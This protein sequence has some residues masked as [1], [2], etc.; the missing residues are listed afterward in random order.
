MAPTRLFR[1]LLFISLSVFGEQGFAQSPFRL[2]G[3]VTD[4]NTG[5]GVPFASVAIQSS[6][7][8]ANT[9]FDGYYDFTYNLPADSLFVTSVGYR[10]TTK[11]IAP[12]LPEQTIHFQMTPEPYAL[13]EVVVR[14]GENPAWAIIRKVVDARKENNPDKQ[15]ATQYESYT[16]TQ[17]DV[18]KLS[19]K[20]RSRKSVKQI[21]SIIDQFDELKG[22]AGETVVPVF[23]SESV[24][25]V[26]LKMDP[27]KR[28][29]VI[30]KT[31][32]SGVGMDDSGLVSQVTGSSF[33]QY[34]FYKDWLRILEK[35]FISPISDSWRL[36]YDYYLADSIKNGDTY[37][38]K[39][40]FEPRRKQDLA[41]VG[42][43]WIDGETF[44]LT[45]VDVSILP[46]TNINYIDNLRIQQE[47][48]QPQEGAAWLPLKTRVVIDVEQ[49]NKTSPGLL[50]KFY[51]ANSNF[52]L[53]QPKPAKFYDTEIELSSDYMDYDSKYWQSKRPENLSESE[54]LSFQVI[55][56]I[57]N[58]PM[59][60]TYTEILNIFVNGYKNID[61]LNIDF[62]PYLYAYAFNNV[63]G[64]RLRLGIKTDEEF[65]R[66]WILSGYGAYGFKDRAFK[67]RVGVDHIFSRKPWTIGGIQ[68]QYD[69][70][71][72][73]LTRETIGGNTIFGAFSRYGNFRRAYMQGD[74]SLYLKR[75]IAKGLTHQIVLRNRTFDPLFPFL[76][77]TD[78][79][80]GEKSPVSS[81]YRTTELEFETRLAH[82]E[83]FL[84]NN[85]ER[86]SL[87]NGN[88]PI[89]SIRYA[90]GLKGMLGG[91]FYYHKLRL[92]VKQS[93][94]LGFVG[95]TTYEANLG[96]IP[97]DLPYPMLYTPLG[98]ESW[99][100][101]ENAFN[102]MNYFEFV[103]DRYATLRVEHDDSGFILNRIPAIRRLKLRLL[104]TGRLYYGD[105]RPGNRNITP[106]NDLEGNPMQTFKT[107]SGKPYVEV[108]YGI[109]NIFRVGRVDFVHRL[110]YRTEPDVSKF[111]VKVSFWFNI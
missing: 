46:Q 50:L 52:V 39:I 7:Y 15:K 35:D 96:Y 41:F 34:N 100:Y 60:R 31:Q 54:K 3:R 12:N 26:Y 68:Y 29:E 44:A 78:L 80:Q 104:A 106:L 70:E 97:S 64:H 59:I 48:A 111:A 86:I 87:G 38:Y 19:E 84:Q 103:S 43:M 66:R 21:T 105:L 82:R 9:D 28:K 69:I 79:S 90:I 58:V 30:R 74:A 55:D 67:Y 24:S 102:L 4:A 16:K 13:K 37:D 85:N 22:E 94:R 57:S 61:K 95:R 75:E 71:R 56:S 14:A 98:N 89:V 49:I 108:G 25:D 45:T 92:N 5:E 76:Y 99:F 72:L 23:I 101:V 73:G 110:T 20:Y 6:V 2:K 77:R 109:N 51:T 10:R 36:Y 17:I 62:G 83:T 11:A 53:D 107:L 91:D 1:L 18:N 93:F 65:S 40:E 32:I 88:A 33:Q 42:S 81:F 47:Y 8:G 63:E 27:F